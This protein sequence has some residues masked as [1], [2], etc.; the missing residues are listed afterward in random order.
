MNIQKCVKEIH[1]ILVI[2]FGVLSHFFLFLKKSSDFCSATFLGGDISSVISS[3][4]SYR[5]EK[6][7]KI[8]KAKQNARTSNS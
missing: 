2:N 5:N 1:N 8:T 4:V 3:H 6:R 7:K